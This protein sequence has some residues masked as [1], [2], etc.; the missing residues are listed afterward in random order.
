[1]TG[2]QISVEPVNSGNHSRHLIFYLYHNYESNK[3]T[4]EKKFVSI[5]VCHVVSV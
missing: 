4:V 1:M 3:K 5:Q 2:K